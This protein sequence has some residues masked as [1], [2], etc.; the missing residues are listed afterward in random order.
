MT[1]KVTSAQAMETPINNS[2]S[3]DF[4]QPDDHIPSI[5]SF[6]F[7]RK[8]LVI[9]HGEF[10]NIKELS[11]VSRCRHLIWIVMFRRLIST[12]L[13]Q[14]MRSTYSASPYETRCSAL[15]GWFSTAV[16][17]AS[18]NFILSFKLDV[19]VSWFELSKHAPISFFCPQML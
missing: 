13:L 1:L 11:F 2:H 4:S 15:I 5:P 7:R 3:Q 17:G 19:V 6:Y 8:V 12:S 14:A 9:H 10:N 18:I 16:T